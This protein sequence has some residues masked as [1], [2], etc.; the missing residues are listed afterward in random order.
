[1][2]CLSEISYH[3]YLPRVN[4]AFQFQSFDDFPDILSN[5]KFLTASAK[6]LLEPPFQ[7]GPVVP[8]VTSLRLAKKDEDFVLRDAKMFRDDSS[9]RRGVSL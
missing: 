1:M 6:P 5:F 7:C 9:H 8:N 3:A 2:A 4:S